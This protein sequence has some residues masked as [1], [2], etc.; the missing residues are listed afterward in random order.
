MY[1]PNATSRA[2]TH[3]D[4]CRRADAHRRRVAR[5][6]Q[7]WVVRNVT[8]PVRQGEVLALIGA[9]GSGKTT[10]LRS[11]NRLTEVTEGSG[12]GGDDRA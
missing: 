3:T 12:A 9:S 1:G 11:L 10:L 8:L 4:A 6:W 5:L 7:H 2:H